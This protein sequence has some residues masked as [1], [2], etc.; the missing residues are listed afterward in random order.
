MTTQKRIV[1]I[2]QSRFGS[3][4]LPGKA[5]QPIGSVPM[6]EHVL[7]RA[8]YA[9]TPTCVVLAT[10]VHERDRPL[11]DVAARMNVPAY[12][13]SERDVLERL[14]GAALSHR[15]D[16]V[17][18]VTG[19]CPLVAPDVIDEVVRAFL[20]SPIGGDYMWNDTSH[21][22]WPDG[23]DVEVFTREALEHAADSA[24]EMHDREHVTPWIRR[25][26]MTGTLRC[27]RGDF[28]RVKL[29]VDT[30]DDLTRVRR[31]WEAVVPYGSDVV[32][33]VYSFDAVMRAA[34]EAGVV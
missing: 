24:V 30:A 27:D 26:H 5:M 4:R 18:R 15:A 21:S 22:G 31:V 25:T 6:I 34:R 3:S 29:S 7:T 2:V 19:D 1:L 33:D 14:R 9:T 10:S 11:V 32:D 28:A 13:G 16:V 17:V 12:C 8:C 23:M 20:V